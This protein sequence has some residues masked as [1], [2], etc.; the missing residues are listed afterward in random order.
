MLLSSFGKKDILQFS[1]DFMEMSRLSKELDKAY[2]ES[3]SDVDLYFKKFEGLI[4]KFNKKYKGITLK[5]EKKAEELET[6]IILSE[7]SLKETFANSASKIQGLQAVGIRTFGELTTENPEQVQ[8]LLEKAK[9][10]LYLTYSIQSGRSNVILTYNKKS[11]KAQL[12]YSLEDIENTSTPEFQIAAYYALKKESDKKI[13]I[14]EE[15]SMLGFSGWPD[16]HE[17]RRTL[18]KFDPHHM[19]E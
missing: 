5:A 11:K 17:K 12:V 4:K 18:E 3:D 8:G 6:Q 13:K 16:H 19:T 14:Y 15:A 1:K 10:N 7:K 2:G 9:D